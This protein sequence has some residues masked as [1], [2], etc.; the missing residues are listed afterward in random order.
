ML[1]KTLSDIHTPELAPYR[2]I[3]SA[4][5]EASNHTATGSSKEMMQN[6]RILPHWA[7]VQV[8]QQ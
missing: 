8:T 1:P 4:L 7:L 2:T 3:H 5:S 6:P